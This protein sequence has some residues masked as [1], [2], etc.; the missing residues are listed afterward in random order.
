MLCPGDVR[1]V[2]VPAVCWNKDSSVLGLLLHGT[3]IPEPFLEAVG[4][5]TP[6]NT[7]RN[8]KGLF[9]FLI[10]IHARKLLIHPGILS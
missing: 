3:H 10:G 2:F 1:A 6:V 8:M 9:S 7:A 4:K 5:G